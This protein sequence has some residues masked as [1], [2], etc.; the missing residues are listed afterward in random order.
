MTESYLIGIGGSG[1]KCVESF[2]HLC[3][4]GLGPENVSI[5]LVDQDQSN[6]NVAKT[7]QTTTKYLS[8]REKVRSLDADT[9]GSNCSYL[10]TAIDFPDNGS[11][12]CP[13]PGTAKTID[14]LFGY[15]SLSDE[16]QGLMDCLYHRRIEQQLPLD[17]GFRGRPSLGAVTVLS[18]A[19]EGQTFW[20]NLFSKIDSAKSGREVRIFLVASIFGGTGASGF[21]SIARRI[22]NYLEDQGISN[23]Y[24]SGALF[25]P[26]FDYSKPEDE[27]GDNET[28]VHSQVFLEQAQGALYYY[29]KMF[30]REH[31]FDNLYFV[32]WDPLIKVKNGGL[33]GN[34]QR[35]P[36]LLPEFYASMAALEF[37]QS[38]EI[39]KSPVYQIGRKSEKLMTWED[40]PT[41]CGSE[42]D[43]QNN[44][45]QMVR[46]C[47]AFKYIYSPHLKKDRWKDISGEEWFKKHIK[48]LGVDLDDDAPQAAIEA[49]EDYTNEFLLWLSSMIYA[50]ST[51]TFLVELFDVHHFASHSP[52]HPTN[53]SQLHER[54]T[55][56]QT[57]SFGSLVTG[58]VTPSLGKVFEEMTYNKRIKDGRGLGEFVSALY[59]SSHV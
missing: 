8:T 35:N 49:L 45:G 23:V 12:W 9:V 57:Q 17:E 43:L 3:A 29:E 48:R 33:G 32:G 36:P 58:I 2:V 31:V 59:S 25:L 20:D 54:L 1:S 19:I 22:R 4:A 15:D 39:P 11:V 5:G 41:L 10:K 52:D 14:E 24:I 28:V 50:S 47:I 44:L 27:N 30:E 13:L 18:Q 56:Q 21:L 6:G 34:Q 46:F 26:Y 51:E 53:S 38:P 42:E 40:F 37:F 55:G 16:L 7:K